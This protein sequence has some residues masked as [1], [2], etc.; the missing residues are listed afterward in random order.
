MIE[1]NP[2]QTL[3]PASST[4]SNELIF[5][6]SAL[7]NYNSLVSTMSPQA[8]LIVLD[9]QIAQIEQITEVLSQYKNVSSFHI[10]SHGEA[11]QL[12]LGDTLLNDS[13]LAQ[14]ETE[15]TGWSNSLSDHADILLY[16]CNI[17]K[18]LKGQSF[19][20][21][22]AQ[23]TG[24]DL[25][26]SSNLTGNQ[27]LGGDWS[28]EYH[29]GSIETTTLQ[30][31]TYGAVLHSNFVEFLDT[32]AKTHTAVKDGS[33]FD[34]STWGASVPGNEAGVFIPAGRKVI[35]DGESSTRLK[36]VR[37]DGALEFATT[38][39]SSM[40]V[41]TFG[42]APTGQLTIGTAT[43]PIQSDKKVT[44]T[45][46]SDTAINT[47]IDPQQ[48]GKGL[49]SHGQARIYGAN[50]LDYVSLQGDALAGSSELILSATPTG[51]QVGDK[52]VLGGTDYN[53]SGS[54]A[55]NTRFEDEVLTITS[56]SGNRI[57]FTNDNITSGNNTIL[58]FDHQR[59]TLSINGNGGTKLY[60]ANTTRNV[61]FQSEQGASTPLLRRGHTMFMHNTDVIIKNAGFYNLGRTDKTKIIN[62][63]G[64]N[65][66]GT[67]GNGTN[68]RGRYPLHFHENGVDDIKGLAAISEGN[69]VVGSPGWGITH[70]DSH[71]NIES[72]VVFDVAGAG[73]AAEHENEI[74][75]WKNNIVIK[76]RGDGNST[77]EPND[78]ARSDRFDFGHE[79]EAYWVQGSGAGLEMVN[80]IAISTAGSGI[81]FMNSRGYIEEYTIPVKNLAPELQSLFTGLGYTEVDPRVLPL[82]K[83]S[84]FEA[85][86]VGF[87]INF[88]QHL[89]NGDGQGVFDDGHPRPAHNV[90]SVV[91]NFK[92]WNVRTT[93]V[94][95]VYTTNLDLVNGLIHG[96]N[97]P[98]GSTGIGGNGASPHH[99]YKNLQIE[100]FKTGIV[101][102]I[103]SVSTTPDLTVPLTASR[104]E[105]SYLAN[106][107]NNFSS[108]LS[109]I[110]KNRD[111]FWYT[112][113]LE[114][115]NTTL[116]GN[117]NNVAPVANF[118]SQASGGL[119]VNFD[120]TSSY[121]PDESSASMPSY[122]SIV[123]YGW[124]FNGDG[125]IDQFGRKV[126]HAFSS[127]GSYPVKLTVWDDQGKTTIIQKTVNVQ[128]TA[129]SNLILD[130]DFSSTQDFVRSVYTYAGSSGEFYSNAS[131]NYGWVASSSQAWKRIGGAAVFVKNVIPSSDN[132]NQFGQVIRDDYMRRGQQQ[133]SVSVKN[134]QV[135]GN[136]NQVTF[137]VW[138][139]N[140]QFGW[141]DAGP[142]KFDAIPMNS[143]KLL[144]QTVGGSTFDWKNFTWDVNFG[145]GY[146]FILI[147]A[148]PNN[149]NQNGGDYLALDNFKIIS[150]TVT[151][152]SQNIN[153]AVVTSNAAIT[154]GNSGSQTLTF[155]VTRTGATQNASSV[156][157]ALAGTATNGSDY[158]SI[159]GTSGATGLTGTI[160]FAANQ[161]SKTITLNVLGD[162]IV[163][164]NET[165]QVSLNNGTAPG[166]TA[167]ITTASATTTISND[168]SNGT[169]TSLFAPTTTPVEPNAT[170]GTGSAGDYELGMEFRTARAGKIT[171]IRYYKAPS[172]TGT[173]IGR[174]WSSTGQLLASVTFTNETT[175]GWQEQ[176]LPT[177]LTIQPNTTYIV[178][179]NCNS[180]YANAENG[181][182]TTITNGDLSA[183]AD[184]SNGVFNT[185]PGLFPTQSWNNSNYY[186]D[187]VFVPT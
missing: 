56:I 100:G 133:L 73:I 43:N 103:E 72:N 166:G 120:A 32:F 76:M 64:T 33:W 123:G 94:G 17:A 68:V 184:G 87:G 13:T 57:R 102:P 126:A 119:G 142:S 182:A 164:P 27:S 16:G 39:N 83:L 42:V 23:L 66:D 163:E 7:S 48:L 46:R 181:L 109:R 52:I 115:V 160:S 136:P 132:D 113:Y 35:Y 4:S 153:Y 165:I 80:N 112:D 92:V 158:N 50:K 10:F 159:G 175:S 162:T 31:E 114:I 82:R 91:D 155:T 29:T 14:Y 138:G 12:K 1:S 127:A 61:I 185:S 55:N 70:H 84:G 40:V 124:D 79:G 156:N 22:L 176:A 150:G 6:D 74:G 77:F 20:Q 34:P 44:I 129:Y 139:I 45:F 78:R 145:N 118:N 105:N 63:V 128:P 177:A 38:K 75:V 98:Y 5:V 97:D 137:K 89:K 178:S 37:V 15:I 65:K 19:V 151:P 62:D 152:P 60:V 28:L 143:T 71:V 53:G 173:H 125:T 144:E 108:F 30:A 146:Q 59:P 51:W 157:Y 131:A 24:A 67:S 130:G 174:I 111:G 170:D 121:D 85:Y 88:Y 183:I 9:S 186:R 25:A 101:P 36:T 90:H 106:N 135:N 116:L 148:T 86:N 54:D 140:G 2:N 168:D 122:D 134:T 69:A 180:H 141:T 41:D 26:A 21:Q 3:N 161:T 171:A 149:V 107:L 49:V 154:E 167:T 18:D 110:I 47:A 95:V 58:R 8:N 172:E 117:S 104:I 147:Q 179:V 93:G 169:S 187:L 99:L 96:S 11:G 81:D